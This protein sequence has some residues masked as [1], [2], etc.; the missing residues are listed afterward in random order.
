MPMI[1]ISNA[2]N[3]RLQALA[4]PLVDTYETVLARILDA[5][6][7]GKGGPSANALASPGAPISDDGRKMEFDWRNAPSLTHTTIT[8][9]KLDS[10]NFVKADTYWNTILLR[11]IEAA[12]KQGMTK[13]AIFAFLKVNKHMG[14]KT[15]NGFK[16]VPDVGISF[17]N[18]TSET[19]FRQIFDLASHCGMKLELHFRWQGKDDAAHPNREGFFR[20]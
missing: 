9:V 10:N 15:I 13:E 2:T 18:G 19:A 7:K 20:I 16:Y 14:E 5:Y 12:H 3:V 11:V 6:E 1:D 17:Q 4:E 8:S